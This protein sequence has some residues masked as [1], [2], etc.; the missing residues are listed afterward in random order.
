MGQRCDYWMA[1]PSLTWCSV[2]L[3]EVGFIS[4]LSPL[5]G[6]LFKVLQFKSWESLTSQLSGAFWRVPSTSCFLR[7]PVS[8]LSAGPQGFCPFPSPN[9][10]SGSPLLLTPPAPST[11]NFPSQVPLSLPTCDCFFSLAKVGLRCPHLNTLASWDFFE[12]CGL[13]HGYSVIFFG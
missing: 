8:I 7:L 12:F 1:T 3:L 5:W 2:F 11:I 10:R 6:I 9:T 13:Y 4:S